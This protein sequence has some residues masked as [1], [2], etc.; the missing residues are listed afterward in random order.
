MDEEEILQY[1][2]DNM[3][4]IEGREIINIDKH[5]SKHVFKE[6][7]SPK[8]PLQLERIDP[9]PLSKIE[10]P[11]TKDIDIRDIIRSESISLPK[12]KEPQ[13]IMK[14]SNKT[15]TG[16]EPAYYTYWDKDKK[17][18]KRRP[19]EKEEYDRYMRENRIRNPQVIKTSF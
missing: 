2:Y 3:W 19:V 18:W 12:G 17:Q 9:L 10:S 6:G 14:K 4:L 5:G 11:D 8:Q 16:Q 7:F 13:L 1:L 15:R